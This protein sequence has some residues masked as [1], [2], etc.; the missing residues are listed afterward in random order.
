[1]IN[2]QYIDFITNSYCTLSV[3]ED[4]TLALSSRLLLKNREKRAILYILIENHD[5]NKSH[6]NKYIKSK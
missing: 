2:F 3:F 4:L 5:S 6:D 1:M